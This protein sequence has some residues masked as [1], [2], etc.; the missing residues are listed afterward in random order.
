[1]LLR[2]YKRHIFFVGWTLWE[3]VVHSVAIW[4]KIKSF[5]RTITIQLTLKRKRQWKTLQSLR[6]FQ[7]LC[8][9][10]YEEIKNTIWFL[11]PPDR[12]FS[13]ANKSFALYVEGNQPTQVS[14]NLNFRKKKKLIFSTSA[15][16]IIRFW[17]PWVKLTTELH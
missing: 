1:M 8:L 3:V 11:T 16:F 13:Q 14:K 4:K 10:S 12:Y 5:F 9:Y 2:W 17:Y 6:Y 7:F 15:Q